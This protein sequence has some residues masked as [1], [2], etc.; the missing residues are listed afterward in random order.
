MELSDTKSE[1]GQGTHLHRIHI[2]PY[3]SASGSGPTHQQEEP[4]SKVPWAL[5]VEVPGHRNRASS[6]LVS[7]KVRFPKG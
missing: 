4:D 6:I 3:L 5:V 7:A 2:T 1:L